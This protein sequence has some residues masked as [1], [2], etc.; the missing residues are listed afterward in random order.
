MEALWNKLIFPLFPHLFAQ[1]ALKEK[2]IDLSDIEA[3]VLGTESEKQPPPE[4]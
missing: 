4:K 2:S 3:D 1:K